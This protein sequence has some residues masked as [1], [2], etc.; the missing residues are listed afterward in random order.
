MLLVQ[1]TTS[2]IA[3]LAQGDSLLFR[4]GGR[5]GRRWSPDR[6]LIRKKGGY[7]AKKR[8]IIH[9]RTPMMNGASH[10]MTSKIAVD[11]DR[12]RVSCRSGRNQESRCAAIRWQ[13][14][15]CLCLER[16]WEFAN[17]QRERRASQKQLFTRCIDGISPTASQ[18]RLMMA[19]LNGRLSSTADNF[20]R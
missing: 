4:R 3:I 14:R 20:F 17:H 7:G 19:G 8:R 16:F 6:I 11:P 1:T 10:S 18:C 9:L 5:K 13:H 15:R 2:L 12:Y